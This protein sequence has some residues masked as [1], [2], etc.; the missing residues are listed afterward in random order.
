MK[1]AGG[2]QAAMKV[3]EE[4]MDFGSEHLQMESVSM[5]DVW[6]FLGSVV[7]AMLWAIVFCMK[8]LLSRRKQKSE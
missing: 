5:W 7:I 1:S 8:R 3:C 2:L 4:E 6:L